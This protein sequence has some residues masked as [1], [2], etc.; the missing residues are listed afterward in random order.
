VA[1]SRFVIAVIARKS[2]ARAERIVTA[3]GY[4]TTARRLIP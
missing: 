1:I 2:E 3:R 4:V